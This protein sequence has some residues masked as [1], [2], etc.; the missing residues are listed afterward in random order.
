MDEAHETCKEM[1]PERTIWNSTPS[2][3]PR[4]TIVTS[5]SPEHRKPKNSAYTSPLLPGFTGLLCPPE[6][7][8]VQGLVALFRKDYKTAQEA[9][10]QVHV[11][12]QIAAHTAGRDDSAQKP[13]G[14]Q[15]LVETQQILADAI[16]VGMREGEAR[17]VRDRAKI[18]HVVVQPLQLQEHDA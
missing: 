6:G 16:T 13:R 5:I 2:G 18:R 1:I 15:I 14:G 3:L 17:I 10:E 4:W 9:F 12:G 11:C 8:A 7:A